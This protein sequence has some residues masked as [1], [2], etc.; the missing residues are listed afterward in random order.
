MKIVLGIPIISIYGL[1]ECTGPVFSTHYKE[2]RSN[3]VGGPFSNLEFKLSNSYDK[4]LIDSPNSKI[5]IIRGEIW[6]RG[7]NVFLGY[8]NNEEETAK[9]L[10]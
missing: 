5:G 3:V 6:I 10:N 7:S 9:V 4:S 8:L 2:K 1:T